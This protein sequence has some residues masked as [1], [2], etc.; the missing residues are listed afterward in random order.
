MIA[1]SQKI[2]DTVNAEELM[3][4]KLF[5]FSQSKNKWHE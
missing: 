1:T 5:E 4:R 2:N 3:S